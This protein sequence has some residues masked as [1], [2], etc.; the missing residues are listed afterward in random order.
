M[1]ERSWRR[2][3]GEACPICVITVSAGAGRADKILRW[4]GGGFIGA[5]GMRKRLALYIRHARVGI[6]KPENS[7]VLAITQMKNRMAKRQ[8]GETAGTSVA[9]WRKCRRRWKASSGHLQRAHHLISGMASCLIKAS[10]RSAIDARS[11]AY[12]NNMATPIDMCAACAA[13]RRRACFWRAVLRACALGLG[14]HIAWRPS[15]HGLPACG[16]VA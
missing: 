10:R 12:R 3:C 9:Q 1:R 4:R 15:W 14:A 7:Y 2:I 5:A 16:E 8:Y 11:R 6:A 13:A